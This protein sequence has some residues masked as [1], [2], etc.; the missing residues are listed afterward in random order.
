MSEAHL[1]IDNLTIRSRIDGGQPLVRDVNFSIRRGDS[2]CVIGETGSGKSLIAQAV[3]GLLPGTLK[4]DG[5]IRIT[6]CPPVS[7]QDT[8]SLRA[9]WSRKT[10]II[11]QE[12]T[13]AF[14]PLMRIG[15]QLGNGH[16]YAAN[17]IHQAFASVDL[18]VSTTMAYPFQLSGGMA[19]RVLVAHASLSDA[20]VIVADEPTKGLDGPRIVQVIALLRQLRDSGKTLLVITHDLNVARELGGRLAVMR[21][22][23]IVESGEATEILKQPS[24]AYT[25]AWLAADPANWPACEIC[26]ETDNMVLAAHGLTVGY[27]TAK[28]LFR[29]LDLHVRKAKVLAVVGPS[30]VGKSTLG[31]VLLGLMA[32]HAGEVSW[33]GCDPYRDRAGARHLRRR[34]Q[35]LHQD[36][37][38]V[39]TSHRTIGAQLADVTADDTK[40][41]A[42]RLPILLERLKLKPELLT[43]RVGEISGGEAQRLALARLL[44]MNPA[45]IVADEPTSRLDP[46]VQQ[47]TMLLLR[48]IVVQDGLALVLISH[49]KDVVKAVADEVIELKAW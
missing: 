40:S 48:D 32:P 30:G 13:N 11:P 46:I 49:Q 25:Q 10:S 1:T 38:T 36:P 18:P 19:Q 41:N 8:K 3:M 26:L 42:T 12:P 35:K 45:L 2:L 5:S 47:Q 14:D 28:P 7:P 33:A 31:N 23:V 20:S 21:D 4:V 34:Y 43:R 6:G 15:S 24:H 29:D 44:L 16:H 17:K 9:L 37:T 39:F 27:G 22:G